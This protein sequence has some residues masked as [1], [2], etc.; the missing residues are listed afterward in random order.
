MSVEVTGAS[1]FVIIRLSSVTHSVNL[2]Q[3]RIVLA[4]RM[5]SPTKYE[6]TVPADRSIVTAGYYYLFA[7]STRN[8]PSIAKFVRIKL[9]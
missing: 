3:R 2:D 8:V 1:S 5:I 6:L 4:S 9:Y 7:M